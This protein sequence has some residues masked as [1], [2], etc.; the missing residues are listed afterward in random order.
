M[1]RHEIVDVEEAPVVDFARRPAP[2]HEPV[3]LRVQQ[4]LHPL[5]S[6][7]PFRPPGRGVFDPPAGLRHQRTQLAKAADGFA[8]QAPPP[9]DRT[10][11]P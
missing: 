1:Q 9:V 3:R 10:G 5:R 7:L 2:I 4:L 11:S 6:A 8:G